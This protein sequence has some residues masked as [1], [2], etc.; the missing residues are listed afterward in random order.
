MGGYKRHEGDAAEI[1]RQI[2][3]RCWNPE[4]EYFQVSN[5]NYP[6]FYCRDFGIATGALLGLGHGEKVRKTLEYA[7]GAFSRHGKIMQV[8]SPHGRPFEFPDY[9]CDA[10][11]F[12]LRSIN[13]S[14][15][16]ELISKYREF[17]NYETSRYYE[18]VFD[19]KT[20]LVKKEPSI[21]GMKD[22]ALRISPCYHNCMLAMLAE[23]LKKAKLDNPFK[24]HDFKRLIKENFWKKTHFIDD[25]SGH[26][27]VTGD[28]N[29]F[30]FWC[31]IFSEKSML[32]SAVAKLRENDLDYPFPLKY[33][34]K[35]VKE[36]DMIWQEF[37]VRNWEKDSIWL[38]LG[39]C[40]LE[41]AKNAD[42][43]L[44]EFYLDKYRGIVE[45]HGN[46][47]ELFEPNGRPFRTAF[48][49][50]DDGMLWS[51]MLLRQLVK[52]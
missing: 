22:F 38:N 21:S 11:P 24:G 5:G 47:L 3:D 19:E 30:P 35:R 1:C 34:G 31:G 46:F 2:V 44:F 20:G 13:L 23:E 52:A 8:I 12:L 33:H 15:A 39:M 27:F 36:H 7:M 51:A 16:T 43:K 41:V 25:L 42:R 45:M 18:K 17:L 10:L 29:V 14:G 28:A 50:A 4:R 49:C 37:F 26:D 40:Y 32:R 48:F 9:S 6:E